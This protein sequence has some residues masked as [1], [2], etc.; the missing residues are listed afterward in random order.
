M[1]SIADAKRF[2]ALMDDNQYIEA[3][4]LMADDCRYTYH[5]NV[6][7]GRDA[8]LKTYIDNYQAALKKLDEIE[9]ISEV[10]QLDEK[11]FK[12]KYLDR[13]RKGQNHHNHRCEQVIYFKNNQIIE[14]EHFDLPGEN[15]A[16]QEFYKR[17]GLK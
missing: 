8:I 1:T 16:L 10:E 3:G 2:A 13:I 11:K 4:K 12:L 6:I 7:I 5:G 9:F 15:E 14:I 17:S